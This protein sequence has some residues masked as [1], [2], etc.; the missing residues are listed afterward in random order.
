MKHVLGMAKR[1]LDLR[2]AKAEKVELDY[3]RLAFA[4]RELRRSGE[5]AMGYLLVMTPAIGKR[6]GG[7][8]AKY[9]TDSEVEVLVAGLTANQHRELTREARAN[10]SGMGA[11][12]PGEAL[13]GRSQ[14]PQRGGAARNT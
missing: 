3:L 10:R 7:W 11:G 2:G 6:A 9:R 13:A 12:T 5:H 8:G 14:S 4:V 1:H